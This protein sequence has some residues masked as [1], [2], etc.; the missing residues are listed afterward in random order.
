MYTAWVYRSAIKPKNLETV[1]MMFSSFWF[2]V[3]LLD[4]ARYT[5]GK[6]TKNSVTLFSFSKQKG[7]VCY[8][9]LA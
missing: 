2:I 1:F 9:A 7:P 8:R 6:S 3:W 5:S 4:Y